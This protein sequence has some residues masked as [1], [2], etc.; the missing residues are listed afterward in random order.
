MHQNT[1]F[2]W[3]IYYFDDAVIIFLG[4]QYIPVQLWPDKMV[5]AQN[6]TDKMVTIFVQISI[7]YI[8]SNQM[9]EISDNNTEGWKQNW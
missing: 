1:H 8:F 3:T 5:Y 9:S 2:N 7:Q 6:G 4:K